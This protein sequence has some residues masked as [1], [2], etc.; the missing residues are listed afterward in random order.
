MAQIEW[1]QEFSVGNAAVDQEHELLIAQINHIYDQLRL[2]LDIFSI[3]SLLTDLQADISSHFA[4]EELLM[5][6][7]GFAEYEAHRQDHQ[8][9]LD[10]INDMIFHF[11][12]DPEEGKHMLKNTLSDWFY[13]HFKS[14]DARLHQLLN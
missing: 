13:H 7:A 11:A 2:P 9:L 3:E 14:F 12:E 5:E 1:R 8:R 4:L 10:Q 6:E